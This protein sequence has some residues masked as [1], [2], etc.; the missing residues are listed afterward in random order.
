M[1]R[2]LIFAVA[3]LVLVAGSVWAQPYYARGDWNGW[4]LSDLLVE[5]TP[6]HYS[7]TVPALIAGEEWEYKL[8]DET[9]SLQAPSDNGK[10]AVDVNGEI[11]FHLYLGPFAD[12]WFPTENRAGYEDPLQFG[13]EIMG[14][15]NGWTDP[16]VSLTAMGN[17]VYAGSFIV[18]DPGEYEFKFR[19]AGDWSI[20][21]GLDFAN[22]AGNIVT[23]TTSA[24]ETVDFELDLR[25]GRWRVSTGLVEPC[26]GDLDGD[27]DVDLADLG[28]LLANFG[29]TP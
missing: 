27:G 11:N 12:G 22:N 7:G 3:S 13:W 16:V 20:S 6:T 18:A 9:Y 17:G 26:V 10:V 2:K 21:I 14:S 4:G 5:I 8:A 1:N 19:K 28:I 25:N 15:F 24:N 29:C 23:S